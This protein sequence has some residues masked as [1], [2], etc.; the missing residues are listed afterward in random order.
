MNPKL[1][2]TIYLDFITSSGTGAAADADS[3][4][5]A[6]VF[7]DAT[8]TTVYALTV[9]KR[10]SKTGDYR[11]AIA[12][13]AANGFE[14][15]KSYNVIASATVGGVAAKAV[16]GRFQVRAKSPD[17]GVT[18]ATGGITSASFAAGAIDASSI[19]TDALGSLELSAGAVAEVAAGVWDLATSGHAT[20]GT[21]GALAADRTGFKLASDGLDSVV[22][23]TGVNFR[24][25]QSVILAYAAGPLSGVD[26]GS[27]VFKAAGSGNS[28]TTRIAATT[29]STGRT[30]VTLTMP[31]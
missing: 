2:E 16:V 17:D 3:L 27:P 21:F 12:C 29:A 14:A 10:T 26:S 30:A 1:E 18:V 13:T 19:A 31:S 20:T 8:D 4:P 23:E 22:I 15:G 5:T 25:S 9:V 24:Q 28:A 7:E 6:E 11:V